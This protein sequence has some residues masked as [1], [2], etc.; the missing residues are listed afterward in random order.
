VN[1]CFIFVG[2]PFVYF[3]VFTVALG[4]KKS[5]SSSITTGPSTEPVSIIICAHDEEQNLR[6]LI[7]MLLRQNYHEF[8]IVVVNDRSNDNTY[9]YLLE[10]GRNDSRV[11]M[12]HVDRVPPHVNAK[13]Y[14]LTLGIKAAKY[15]LLLLTDADCR[16]EGDAWISS[17][18]EAFEAR[19][20]FVLGF[21]PYTKART[22]SM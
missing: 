11:R 21:S 19:T 10:T 6:E 4:R 2:K 15:D 18:S 13:K 3:V 22:T 14:S 20:Q 5:S 17:M 7:P 1:D 8:E 12:V 9:D 16:P